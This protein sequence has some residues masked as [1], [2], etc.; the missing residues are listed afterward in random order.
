MAEK[1]QLHD[2][3][4]YRFGIAEKFTKDFHEEV[5]RCV[6]DYELRE[7]DDEKLE[8]LV[9]INSR[10]EFDI[11]YIFATHE[12]MLASMFDKIPDLIFRGRG[13]DDDTKRQKIEAAYEYLSDK[14]DFEHFMTETA[15]WFILIGWA[16]AHGYFK[17]ETEEV[18]VYDEMGE[19]MIDPE[20]G[21][22]MTREMYVYNDPVLMIGD[23]MKEY[24]SP[25]SKFSN[26][27]SEVP[28]FF[29]V[30]NMEVGYI[31][32]VYGKKVEA[33]A[34]IKVNGISDKQLDNDDIKRV[35]VYFYYGTLPEK[36]KSEVEDWT[37]DSKYYVVFTDKELLHKEKLDEMPCRLGKWHGVPSSFFGFG[38][39][40]I[41]RAFQK[42]LSI[43]RG[44]QVRYADLMA[45]PK[46]AYDLESEVDEKALLDP[47]AGIVMGFRGNPPS[48]IAPPAMPPTILAAEEKAR[49]DAQFVSGMLDLSKGAS[50]SKVVDT[51]TGQAI[52]AE[53]AEKRIRQAKRQYG[54]FYRSVIIMLLKLAQ[55]HWDEEKL[56]SIT[57]DDGEQIDVP[58]SGQDLQDIDF[59]LDLDIDMESVSVNKD[60]LRAQAIELYDRVKDD[61]LIDRRMVFKNKLL[62]EGFGE[63]NPEIYMIQDEE[64]GM[65][66][67]QGEQQIPMDGSMSQPLSAPEGGMGGVPS[68]QSG[69]TGAGNSL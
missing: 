45:F 38:I 57:D 66:A 9:N 59:D 37:Y 15:W 63:R 40:K 30:E 51:A 56:I 7:A 42:E 34:S 47:R 43:R 23:P 46:I 5:E 24:F 49:E 16:S 69:I 22:M 13:G 35:K 41:L 18:P 48:Y 12:S 21:E 39:G 19:P 6:D 26:E 55:K 10:Y 8:K 53:A 17:S 67:M 50:E 44:Q 32:E 64:L 58:V 28:F 60:V 52:F 27:A 3:V 2:L 4:K 54:R 29:K 1:K 20:T 36:V 33:D 62:R 11:P 25:E 68:S 14:L 31:K 61:P 65:Q